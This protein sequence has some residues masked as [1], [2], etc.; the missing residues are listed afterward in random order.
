MQLLIATRNRHKVR[1][2]GQILRLPGVEL[3]DLAAY[4][5]LPEVEED[6]STFE[7]N[8]VK[9][10]VTTAR[11]T[12]CWTLAD[13][14]GLEIAALD[15]RPGVL[16]ARYAGEPPDYAANNRKVLAEM[17]G[18]AERRARFRCV[19]A[20]A[21]PAGRFWTV[22]GRCEGRIA[23]APRGQGGFGYD[24]IFVPLGHEQTFAEMASE[25]KNRI[26]HRAAALR[27]AAAAWTERLADA[28]AAP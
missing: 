5:D 27:Q 8:A 25:L 20:L 4:P 11:A 16:S 28:A 2:I 17:A 26:S 3:R 10:A 6:G 1:E 9:K 21:D 14:S 7:A 22:E 12:G 23:D 18:V 24:P 19:L 15:G 13:D